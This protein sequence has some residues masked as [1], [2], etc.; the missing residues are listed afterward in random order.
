M[1]PH[2]GELGELVASWGLLGVGL[3]ALALAVNVLR[4]V[5][6]YGGLSIVSFFAGWL[7]GELAL[8]AAVVTF[9]GAGGL[10]V[11]GAHE[12]WAG[13][14]GIGVSLAALVVLFVG[15]VRA[16]RAH[17]A[18]T[19]AL[20]ELDDGDAA[21]V[22]VPRPVVSRWHVEFHSYG[23]VTLR[24]DV[25]R[26]RDGSGPRPL[27][28]YVH[29]GA[30]MIGHR[31]RQ[32]L[33]LMKY[34]AARG[35]ICIS[36]D[37]RLSPRAT[38]PEHLVDV[39][40]A[41]VWVRDHA[42]ELGGDPAFLSIAGNSAGGHLA[43]LAALTANRP[44]YQPGFEDRD[45]TVDACVGF[46]GIYDFTDRWGHWPHPGMKDLLERHVMKARLEEARDAYAAA[47]PVDQVHAGAP[48]FL[49]VHGTHDSLAPCDESRRLHEKL[50]AVSRSPAFCLEV[51]GAQHAFE[52]F[53]S[54]RTRHVVRGAARFLEWARERA[55]VR[56]RQANRADTPARSFEPPAATRSARA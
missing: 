49:L 4:P 17:R 34:L 28:L 8:Y 37:Y 25:H 50:R 43:A 22:V 36:V 51:P 6:A 20:A 14:V 41:I 13:R 21:Q 47:S 7:V 46:Y 16:A 42:A 11:L 40:R 23:D 33:P 2:R 15:H 55:R 39:K 38:F 5:R 48:P 18:V 45:T 19:S 12:T 53:P 54:A 29:G 32:G 44:E 26:A 24:L 56:D 10:C 27:L 31:E 1:G 9:L 30:W 3:V 52:V 35:W